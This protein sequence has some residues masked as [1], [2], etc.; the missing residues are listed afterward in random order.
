[1]LA[2][3]LTPTQPS[4]T[5]ELSPTDSS[6]ER[7]V[8]LSFKTHFGP[9]DSGLVLQLAPFYKGEPGVGIAGGETGDV[10]VKQS[11]ADNDGNWQDHVTLS[12]VG[13]KLAD[14]TLATGELGWNTG[15]GVPDIALLNGVTAHLGEELVRVV[16]STAEAI[17]RG[18]TL[19]FAG[20]SGNSGKIKVAKMVADGSQPAYVFFGIAA[21]AIPA[22]GEGYSLGYGRLRNLATSE[23]PDGTILWC[24]PENAGALTGEEPD[25]PNLKLPVAAVVHSHSNGTLFVRRTTGASLKD[26]HDVS[27]SDLED[28]DSIFWNETT[29]RF[30][31]K[32]LQEK[33]VSGENIKT[34]SGI[35]L[36]GEGDLRTWADYATS[37]SIE[38]AEQAYTA[39][40]FKVFRYQKGSETVYRTVPNAY[41]ATLDAFYTTF[42][43][44]NFPTGLIVTRG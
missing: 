37:W 22:N 17:P 38:P 11:S 3:K 12:K 34:V 39:S 16:N 20:T 42:D 21:S 26:L 2:L 25:A 7:G 8:A 43:G 5:L 23:W 15:E 10:F 14:Q 32:P 18:T 24:D 31:F 35:S 36:L 4:L 27:V 28:G 40:D 19:M 44:T 29:S 1:M 33:L 13:L 9:E 30:E 6:L 41:D